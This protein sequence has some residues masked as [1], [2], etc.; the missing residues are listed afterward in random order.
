MATPYPWQINPGFPLGIHGWGTGTHRNTSTVLLAAPSTNPPLWGAWSLMG[1]MVGVAYDEQW[2][3]EGC[4]TP[5]TY[6]LL[7]GTLPTGTSLGNLTGAGGHISG[8]PTTA[9][10]YSFTLRATNTYGI[11]DK[12]FSITITS[13]AGGGAW[14]WVS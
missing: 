7:S 11:A 3:L 8:T 4:A 14:A 13:P 10:T 9:G 6:T 5:T 2:Y 1:G 12:A